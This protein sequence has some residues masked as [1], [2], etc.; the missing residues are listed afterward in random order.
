MGRGHSRRGLDGEGKEEERGAPP[1]PGHVT[2]PSPVAMWAG[3]GGAA[4]WPRW[5]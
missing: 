1:Q 5:A 4:L 2:C 3:L